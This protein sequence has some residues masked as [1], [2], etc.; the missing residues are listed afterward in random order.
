MLTPAKELEWYELVIG[1]LAIIYGAVKI[2]FGLMSIFVPL[3]VRR[4][5]PLLHKILSDDTTAA[6]KVVE[7][8]LVVFGLYSVIHA[9]DLLGYIQVPWINT[10]SF[11][12]SFYT[13][14]GIVL[15]TFYYLV[16]YTNAKIQ[17]NSDEMNKYKLLG[18]LGGFG[19][20][21]MT[22]LFILYH[23]WVDHGF[24]GAVTHG[25]MKTAGAFVFLLL[26]LAGIGL[27]IR[28]YMKPPA[29]P[30]KKAP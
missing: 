14:L 6:A 8:S 23:Q 25:I 5:Y 7:G 28:S 24:H 16:I 4:K 10:R 1:V 19:F 29:P 21:I 2:T 15:I 13:T 17:K 30:P 12:Y 22:P 26:I 9:L 27:T 11:I 20:L 18:L 3:S